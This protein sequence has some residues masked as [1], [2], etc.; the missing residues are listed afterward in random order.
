MVRIPG[1]HCCGPGQGAEILKQCDGLMVRIPGF[2]CCGPG[3]GAEILK[4]CDG[5]RN[6]QTRL[7]MR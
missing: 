7:R 1:F 3:Q 6:T 4:Q 5:T 2:H